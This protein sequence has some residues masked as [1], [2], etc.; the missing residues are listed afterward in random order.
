MRVRVRLRLRVRA[1]LVRVQARAELVTR[2]AQQVHA[3]RVEIVLGLVEQLGL[4]V[5]DDPP[6]AC[7]KVGLG[8][9][10]AGPFEQL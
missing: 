9:G 2:L 10:R 6:V 5:G 1:Y 4:R 8:M 7:D 3:D